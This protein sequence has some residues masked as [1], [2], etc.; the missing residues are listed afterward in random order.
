MKLNSF[1]V[2]TGK[3]MVDSMESAKDFLAQH[4]H[5]QQL[6]EET[7]SDP[8]QSSADTYIDLHAAIERLR[9]EYR[10]VIKLYYLDDLPVKQIAQVL[11]RN[12]NTIK[13]QLSRARE[14]LK[15]MLEA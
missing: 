9:P 6:C 5:H 3:P 1:K 14:A 2:R 7:A 15:T 8:A 10:E 13:T 12:E 4:S 11:G